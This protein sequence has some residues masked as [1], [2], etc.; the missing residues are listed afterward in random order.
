VDESQLVPEDTWRRLLVPG[1]G[2][3]SGTDLG[4]VDLPFEGTFFYLCIV[5]GPDKR[6]KRIEYISCISE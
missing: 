6:G 2:P 5:A 3:L 1:K 4:E